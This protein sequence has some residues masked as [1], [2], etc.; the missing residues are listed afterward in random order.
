MQTKRPEV[1][2]E[3]FVLHKDGSKTPFKIKGFASDPKVVAQGHNLA[4]IK[5]MRIRGSIAVSLLLIFTALLGAAGGFFALI[6]AV[7]HSTAVR[8]G[9]ADYVVD[10]IDTGTASPNLGTLVFRANAS[11]EAE[12]A[13][14]TFANPAFGNA[15]GG[16]ATANSI[17]SDTNATGGT[18]GIFTIHDSDGTEILRGSVTATSGGGDIELSSVSIGA[19]DTVSM[20]SLTYSAP[21]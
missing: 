8:N 16:T 7:T 18:A 3:G 21:S 10:L 1:E 6:G 14:L 20:T 12:V 4:G 13:T 2:G 5:Q 9:I 11:P 15:T 17:A 19:S